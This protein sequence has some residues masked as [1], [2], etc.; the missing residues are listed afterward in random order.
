[1]KGVFFMI[2]KKGICTL[3]AAVIGVFSAV[4]AFADAE[5][6]LPVP[7]ADENG[8]YCHAGIVW[9]I[10]DQW[11]HRNE[12]NL[13]ALDETETYVVGVTHKDVNIT[14]NGEYT[15]E[16]SGY[17]PDYDYDMG[18][19]GV[20]LD[21]DFDTYADVEA[22][23]GVRFEITKAVVDG[24]EYTY[25]NELNEDGVLEQV[26]E[27]VERGE[28]GQK[29]I[30]IKNSW[31]EQPEFSDPVMD[32]KIW[33]TPDP[34]TI[35]FTVS[36]LPTDK[37][38]DNPDE[39]IDKVYGEG[40]TDLTAGFE[41]SEAETTDETTDDADKD[42]AVEDDGAAENVEEA[43]SSA[44]KTDSSKADDTDEDDEDSNLPL[45]LGICGGAVVVIAVVAVVIVKKK[46]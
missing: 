45:I 40:F 29:L 14:G 36:G 4:P 15:V 17:K 46:K 28:N 27:D 16:M 32:N 30:K 2:F 7:E 23:K 41:V 10:K 12:I 13:D 33:K 35:T 1:M 5:S 9:Q 8:V 20:E 22:D 42:E 44:A 34:I 21:L 26:L 31:G 6:D 18:F 37:I 11:D 39:V 3:C 24:V 38:E 19:L 25:K 43:S